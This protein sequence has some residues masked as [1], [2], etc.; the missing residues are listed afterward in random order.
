VQFCPDKIRELLASGP[1]TVANMREHQEA[2]AAAHT[3]GKKFFVM[4]GEHVT[5]NDMLIAAELNQRKA[6]A[7]VRETDKKS[8]VEYHVRREAT[9]PI[10]DCLKNELENDVGRLKSKELENLLRWKGVLVSTMGNVANRS[11][12]YQQFAEGGAEDEVGIVPAPWMEINEAELIA[13]RDGPIAI[14]DTA[15]GRFEEQ[16]KRDVERAY[17]KMTAT[18][19]EVFKQKM[20]E[21][22]ELDADDGETPPPTPTP[23]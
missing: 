23:V 5:S 18:E 12:L 11:I 16:K 14:C 15:Y 19:N 13:L 3:H 7:T 6:E 22:D 10:V 1:V 4:G 20:A 8:R 17:Q 9:L 2:L 21:Y